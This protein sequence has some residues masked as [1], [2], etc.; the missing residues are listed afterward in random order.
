MNNEQ[1][2]KLIIDNQNLIYSISHKFKKYQNKEDLF[3]VGCIGLIKAHDNFDDSFR[4]KF[5]T[6]AYSYILGEM[7]KYINHDRGVKVNRDLLKLNLKIEKANI[8]LAQKLMR[9]PTTKEIS[10]YLELPEF[11]IYQ[12]LNVN[13]PIQS[14]SVPINNNDD[15]EMTLHDTVAIV[16]NL[17][18]T[19]LIALTEEINH[20]NNQDQQI[21]KMRYYEDMTQT[22]VADVLGINQV[23]VSR[24]EKYIL[25]KLRKQLNN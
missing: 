11:V 12:A 5:S 25:Q 23:Q 3:Q 17:D 10:S 15:K 21:I 8:L 14:F 24:K 18:L 9:E 1:V 6:Y 20:L 7:K 19:L 13:S 22:E 2:S 16:N 4:V